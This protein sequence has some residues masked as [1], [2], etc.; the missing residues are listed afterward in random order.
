[1][2]KDSFEEF[3][4]EGDEE[5]SFITLSEKEFCRT[6]LTFLFMKCLNMPK[7]DMFQRKLFATFGTLF[8]CNIFT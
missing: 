6:F 8:S 1:M 3:G 5:K 4:D 2:K 7:Q